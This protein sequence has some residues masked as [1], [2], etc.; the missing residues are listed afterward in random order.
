MAREN[1]S[2][3]PDP[4]GWFTRAKVEPGLLEGRVD[5]VRI[6]FHGGRDSLIPEVLLRRGSLFLRLFRGRS[7][8]TDE[9]DRDGGRQYHKG[10]ERETNDRDAPESRGGRGGGGACQEVLLG[11]CLSL[12]DRHVLEERL[13]PRGG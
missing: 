5:L 7:A 12:K 4:F 9:R 1:R 10:E 6:P 8:A 2:A 3:G 11:K 13:V